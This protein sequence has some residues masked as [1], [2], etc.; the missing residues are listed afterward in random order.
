MRMLMAHWTL[1]GGGGG[2]MVMKHLSE[3]KRS[4]GHQVDFLTT[5]EPG[6]GSKSFCPHAMSIGTSAIRVS[7]RTNTSSACGTRYSLGDYDMLVT[8]HSLQA[9]A[10]AGLLHR[11]SLRS[12]SSTR[13]Q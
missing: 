8:H 7:R 10:V 6:A 1:C 13:I 12:Q 11:R 5:V 3:H 9:V 4:L 2:Q